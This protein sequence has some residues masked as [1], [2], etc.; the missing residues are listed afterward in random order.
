M[1]SRA[2]HEIFVS[3]IGFGVGGESMWLVPSTL[4]KQMKWVQQASN[5]LVAAGTVISFLFLIL[6]TISVVGFMARTY[7][8]GTRLSETSLIDFLFFNK[9]L[10]VVLIGILLVNLGYIMW[11]LRWIALNTSQ[12]D[13]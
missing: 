9:Y 6:W 8:A 10:L 11:T 1:L 2:E 5:T 12:V 4:Q 3:T 7:E 13:K